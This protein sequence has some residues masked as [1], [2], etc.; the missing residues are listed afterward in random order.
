MTERKNMTKSERSELNTFLIELGKMIL[1][2]AVIIS[3][4]WIIPYLTAA[5]VA[6]LAFYPAMIFG[7]TGYTDGFN[8]LL[9]LLSW[10]PSHESILVVRT[11][12]IILT[13]L[14][15]CYMTY[16]TWKN[17]VEREN[18]QRQEIIDL[19]KKISD[20]KTKGDDR[21]DETDREK[22]GSGRKNPSDTSMDS[23]IDT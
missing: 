11:L 12:M 16:I 1:Y 8:A 2:T 18:R 13:I 7:M 9:P 4:Y 22:E 21:K 17:D 15:S 19:R 3:G 20:I 6:S 23:G 10:P 14:F 5:V